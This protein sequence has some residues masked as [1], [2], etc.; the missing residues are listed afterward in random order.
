MTIDWSY[1]PQWPA[2]AG[3]LMTGCRSLHAAQ[4]TD[5]RH[6]RDRKRRPN[7]WQLLEASADA[8]PVNACSRR[9]SEADSTREVP[10]QH[11]LILALY[12]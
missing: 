3:S 9:L 11:P 5:R 12:T 1:L 6:P 8:G 10:P 4:R 7:Y 2:S